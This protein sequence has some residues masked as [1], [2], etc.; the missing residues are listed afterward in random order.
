MRTIFR[1]EAK[2]NSNIQNEIDE[3]KAKHLNFNAAFLTF[4]VAIAALFTFLLN[5]VEFDSDADSLLIS[6][7]EKLDTEGKII[8]ILIVTTILV[9][10]PLVFMH[11]FLARQGLKIANNSLNLKRLMEKLEK[12]LETN[13]AISENIEKAPLVNLISWS[14]AESYEKRAEKVWAISYSLE[15]LTESRIS[16]ILD[17]L[18]SNKLH[19]YHYIV[20]HD[21]YLSYNEK[22]D[23]VNAII[24]KIN[25]YETED[26]SDISE[27]FIIKMAKENQKF[28]LPNDI[29]IYQSSINDCSTDDI[30]VLNTHEFCSKNKVEE[31]K[32][33][34]FDLRFKDHKQ[35]RRLK[36]WYESYWNTPEN[37]HK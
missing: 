7:V 33:N 25:C 6:I 17:E 21:G 8:I 9:V 14:D 35:I 3:F 31:N 12:Q 34:N 24:K 18:N 13:L 30:I 26:D 29:A 27:R 15:W 2:H 11:W 37:F 23:K 10:G 5:F 4:V 22:E 36:E 32:L 19:E 28:P 16:E 20:A 1:K